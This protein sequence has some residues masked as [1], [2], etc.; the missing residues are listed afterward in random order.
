VIER[1]SKKEGAKAGT[2]SSQRAGLF[3]IGVVAGDWSRM[4]GHPEV[5]RRRASGRLALQAGCATARITLIPEVIRPG[6]QTRSD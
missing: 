2:L 5:G 4:V 3:D 6:W 1:Q